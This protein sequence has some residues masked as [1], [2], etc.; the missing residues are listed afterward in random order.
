MDI[1]NTSG[2]NRPCR[3]FFSETSA[4]RRV[5]H[6]GDGERGSGPAPGRGHDRV[7]HGPAPSRPNQDGV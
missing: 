5:R 2:R 1:E 4:G 3:D 7:P 6:H